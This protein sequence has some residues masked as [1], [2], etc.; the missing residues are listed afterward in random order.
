MLEAA[1]RTLVIE[2][3]APLQIIAHTLKGHLGLAV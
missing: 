2:I 3:D 1:I